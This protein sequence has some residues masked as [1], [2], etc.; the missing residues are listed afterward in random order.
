[1]DPLKVLNVVVLRYEEVSFGAVDRRR[2]CTIDNRLPLCDNLQD[3]VLGGR[4][5]ERVLQQS[6]RQTYCEVVNA[7]HVVVGR[8]LQK[9]YHERDVYVGRVVCEHAYEPAVRLDLI[10]RGGHA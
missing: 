7:H 4:L 5:G 6:N 2:Q 1:M 9:R 8:T 3:D 10:Y